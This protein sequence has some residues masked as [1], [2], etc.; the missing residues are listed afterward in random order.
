MFYFC[1]PPFAISYFCVTTDFNFSMNLSNENF[2]PVEEGSLS[3][4]FFIV[5]YHER[6]NSLDQKVLLIKVFVHVQIQLLSTLETSYLSYEFV[7][8]NKFGQK[9]TWKMITLI[10]ESKRWYLKVKCNYS[11]FIFN[12]LSHFSSFLQVWFLTWLFQTKIFHMFP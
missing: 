1:L 2:V 7:R 3:K 12:L 4:S 11:S 8:E 9:L 5:F 6:E 10:S